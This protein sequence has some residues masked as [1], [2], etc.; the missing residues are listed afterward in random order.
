MADQDRQNLGLYEAHSPPENSGAEVD[1]ARAAKIGS[2]K[3][4]IEADMA[5]LAAQLVADDEADQPSLMLDE[6]DEQLA[7][8]SGPVRHVASAIEEA[9]G[10]GRGRPKGSQN[11]ANAEF[12]DVLLRMGFRH[13]GLNLA[14][15]A[16]ADPIALA[17][18]LTGLDNV[19]TSPDPRDRLRHM[20]QAGLLKMDQVIAVISK[21]QDMQHRANAELL[22]YFE[23]KRPT[24]LKVDKNVRGVM[25]V[26]DFDMRRADD[27]GMID[28]TKAPKPE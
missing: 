27:E 24:E 4:A 1:Q 7:L 23:S 10:R 16:N 19:G 8:F 6:A 18:E 2:G 14:A 15:V 13:P 17:L 28:V 21:A 3:A 5:D 26:G 12:R 20:V 11:K 9:R 25:F 22:P